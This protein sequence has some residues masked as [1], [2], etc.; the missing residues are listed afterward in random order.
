MKGTNSQGSGQW[1]PVGH[2]QSAESGVQTRP[3]PVS[4][5]MSDSRAIWPP[6]A[7]TTCIYYIYIYFFYKCIINILSRFHKNQV[8]WLG[9]HWNIYYTYIFIYT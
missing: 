7:L 8:S 3:L 2:L 5:L 6:G 4:T 9:I 1:R